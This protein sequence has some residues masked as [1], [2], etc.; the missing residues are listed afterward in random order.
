MV[1]HPHLPPLGAP[2][3]VRSVTGCVR[4]DPGAGAPARVLPCTLLLRCQRRRSGPHVDGVD[5][6]GTDDYRDP[7]LAGPVA[8]PQVGVVLRTDPI[9]TRARTSWRPP[10]VLPAKA[11]PC[12]HTQAE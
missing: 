8:V 11:S 6:H 5:A 4:R 12:D 2:F 9:G 1:R 3:L 10:L 7:R